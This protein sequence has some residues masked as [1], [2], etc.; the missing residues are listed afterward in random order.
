MKNQYT[1]LTEMLTELNN[2]YDNSI[3]EVR[4]ARESVEN[5]TNKIDDLTLKMDL[6]SQ[7]PISKKIN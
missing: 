5:I 7:E 6:Y 1:E 3:R 4:S 2:L